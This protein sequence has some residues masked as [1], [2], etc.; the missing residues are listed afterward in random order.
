MND[1]VPGATTVLMHDMGLNDAAIEQRKKIVAL[2]PD[3]VRRIVALRDIVTPRV[4]AYTQSFFDHLAGLEDARGLTSSKALLDRAKRLKREHLIAMVAGEFGSSYVAQRLELASVYAAAN[5]DARAFLGAFH[6][7]LHELGVDVIKSFERSPV[8]GFESFMSLEKLAFFDIS[9]IVDVLVYQ[10]ERLIRQQQEAIRELSTPVLQIR[11]RLL[12]LPI[13]GVIDTH[14]ARLITE[15]L[16]HAIRTNRAKAVVMDVTG[17]ATIDSRVAH[18]ILQT[19][20]AARL[21]G[22]RVI[23]TGLSAEV[24][25][26]LAALG[27]ELSRL[28]TVGDLQGGLEEAEILLG[29]KIRPEGDA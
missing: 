19:V 28:N 1:R 4:D 11:D 14:R 13:I 23:V 20:T 7:L 21:M 16:L 12:L 2:G 25:Q 24:A 3:D 9:V 17:V 27:I 8:D 10:R 18:H 5:L 22:A 29:L 15:G 6:Q 26:S